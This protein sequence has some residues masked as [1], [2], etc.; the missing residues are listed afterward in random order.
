MRSEFL[1][2]ALAALP[3]LIA[4]QSS[5][6]TP[7]PAGFTSAISAAYTFRDQFYSS[8]SESVL[9]AYATVPTSIQNA[10][11]SFLG[12][13]AA[14]PTPVPIPAAFSVYPSEILG[15]VTSFEAKIISAVTANH[16]T[17]A[18]ARFASEDVFYSTLF[19]CEATATAAN[20]AAF[21]GNPSASA[22][23]SASQSQSTAVAAAASTAVARNSANGTA[24]T[25]TTVVAGGGGVGAGP[26]STQL[27]VLSATGSSSTAPASSST[28]S[29][30]AAQVTPMAVLVGAF[31]G[32]ALAL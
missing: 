12:S 2:P 7:N 24:A 29:A 30:G 26:K 27:V 9:N 20:V 4:A 17:D 6:P 23:A 21:C 1:L 22:S 25:T 32:L 11:N 10:F 16:I 15:F 31:A 13:A 5:A 14:Q 19:A 18:S 28:R 3:V 8:A